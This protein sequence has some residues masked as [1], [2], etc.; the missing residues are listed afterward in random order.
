MSW[1]RPPRKTSWPK[2]QPKKINSD[3]IR[4]G[5]K[6]TKMRKNSSDEQMWKVPFMRS[7]PA[8]QQNPIGPCAHTT[9]PDKSLLS[10]SRA[11]CREIWG[12]ELFSTD[13]ERK[14]MLSFLL[15]WLPWKLLDLPQ[16]P[17]PWATGPKRLL[18]NILKVLPASCSITGS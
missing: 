11:K 16:K 2:N 17:A 18:F 4:M 3:L 12:Q 7:L 8:L 10:R 13:K 1:P 5:N 15:M 9:N 6:Q 14:G